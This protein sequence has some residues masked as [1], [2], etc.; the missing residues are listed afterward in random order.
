MMNDASKILDSI[1]SDDSEDTVEELKND[2]KAMKKKAR[3]KMK[4]RSGL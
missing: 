2:A 4:E 1:D 3:A